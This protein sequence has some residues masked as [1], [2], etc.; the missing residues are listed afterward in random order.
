MLPS[1]TVQQI[2]KD[3]HHSGK[4]TTNFFPDAQQH[5]NIKIMEI[6]MEQLQENNLTKNPTSFKKKLNKK[7]TPEKLLFV[8]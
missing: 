3:H 1:F 5:G 8:G 6:F 7:D 4:V 2:Q